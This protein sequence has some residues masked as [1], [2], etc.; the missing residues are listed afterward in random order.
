[1]TSY[2]QTAIIPNM[3]V[4]YISMRLNMKSYRATPKKIILS[5]GYY[6]NQN[7][8]TVLFLIK[9]LLFGKIPVRICTKGVTF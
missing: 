8:V 3:Y 7:A 1:M 2:E 6:F 5:G 4:L 9:M